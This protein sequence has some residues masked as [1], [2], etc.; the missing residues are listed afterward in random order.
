MS[1]RIFYDGLNLALERGTGIATYTRMLAALAHEAGDEVGLV[2]SSPRRPLRDRSRRELDFLPPR[3]AGQRVSSI[4]AQQRDIAGLLRCPFGVRPRPIELPE[5]ARDRVPAHQYL[6]VARA[7]F[8]IA[9]RYFAWT[10]RSIE[11]SFPVQ[12]DILHCTYPM[13]LRAKG[14]R[15]IYTI[16][17]LIPL[18]LPQTTLDNKRQIRRRLAR[19]AAEAD[20]IVTVSE[21]SRRD[22]IE[23]LD[24]DAQRVTNTYEAVAFAP[25]DV[26]RPDDEVAAELE[27]KFSLR[28][29]GYLLFFGAIEPKKNVKALLDAYLSA[30]VAM[31]LII[32]S[33]G[34]WSNAVETRML[35]AIEAQESALPVHKRRVRRLDYVSRAALI[36]LIRGAAAVLFP[37]LYE[38]FG[39]PVLEAMTLGAPVIT[40]R[41]SSLPEIGGDAVLYIDPHDTADIARAIKTVVADPDLRADMIARGH[42]QAELFSVARYRA[43]VAALYRSLA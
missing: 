13:P 38:G 30:S 10:G 35:A 36:S 21:H 18:R 17:D 7:L 29:R 14:A 5:A 11:L 16:H 42:Q 25:G 26:A 15:N 2:Y 22:I 3:P 43:R 34:G 28:H 37:S 31:P 6:F 39:L 1:R 33:G 9:T 4:W 32:V 23:L 41:L 12:P 8:D 19:I 20:H 40:S 24:I 27:T